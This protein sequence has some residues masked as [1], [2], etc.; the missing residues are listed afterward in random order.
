MPQKGNADNQANSYDAIFAL[1]A[2]VLILATVLLTIGGIY[3]N[4]I[5]PSF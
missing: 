1:L 3:Y 2:F 4:F 5:N